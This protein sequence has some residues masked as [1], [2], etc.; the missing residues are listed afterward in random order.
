LFLLDA[1]A[2]TE[3]GYAG[4]MSSTICAGKKYTE[5]QRQIINIQNEMYDEA[6]K[7]LKPGV[8]YKDVHDLSA[9]VMIERM[10][11]IGLMK[12]NTDDCLECGAFALFFVHGLGHMMGLDVHDMENFG[13]VWVGYNGQ[14]KS[15]QFGRKSL[16]LAIPLEPGFVHTIEP[17]IYF[18]PQ[19]IDKWRAEKKFMDFINYDMADTYKD[20]GGVRNESDYLITETGSHRLGKVVPK[21]PDAI[22]ALR[23]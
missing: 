20:F 8:P 4:D 2:E 12:G 18:I 1:G 23:K 22:E 3:M 13:E 14:P 10:K 11:E 19:L 6:V 15:T 7:A 5:R 21:E 17:G 9:R 16:R